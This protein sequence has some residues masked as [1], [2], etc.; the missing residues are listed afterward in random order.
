MNT[1]KPYR[2]TLPGTSSSE[3]RVRMVRAALATAALSLAS[4]AALRLARNPRTRQVLSGKVVVITGASTGI[5]RAVALECVARG[6]K[7]VLAARNEA[8]LEKVAQEARSL[9]GEALV[10]ATDVSER[11]QVE[12][13]IHAAQAH[14]GRIDVMMNHAGEWFLDSVEHSEEH[15]VRHLIEVN[16][17]GVL[18][19]VQAVLPV[20]RRQ[21]FGHII[22]TA[23]VESRVGFPYSG[24]YAGSKAFVELMTQS[25][26]QE[27]MH[28]EKTPIKVTALLPTAIRTPFFDEG[29]NVKAGGKGMHLVRPVAEPTT[30]AKAIVNAMEH[31]R[32]VVYSLPLGKQFA[33]MYDLLPGLTDRMMS[34][35]RTDEHANALSHAERGSHR[36]DR[37]IPPVVENGVLRD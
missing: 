30:V 2:D 6:A 4:A 7:V 3:R 21:G 22:N 17:M 33:L 12:N 19:G 23:S 31:Y 16:V 26:R 37:P 18:N 5:G 24:I 28:V 29:D 27:L 15:R 32:P 36:Q 34:R 9:G 8:A 11:Q 13:L 20:M 1:P 25:L 14:Y 10:V 35:M